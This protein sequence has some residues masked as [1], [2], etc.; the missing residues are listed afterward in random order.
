MTTKRIGYSRISTADQT[1]DSQKDA[2]LKAGVDYIYSDIYTGTKAS[3]PELDR[4]KDQ[5]R[6]G[7]TIVIT[8]LDRLGRSTKDL[9]K[10]SNDFSQNKHCS[11]DVFRRQVCL[12]DC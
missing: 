2:L 5:L 6:A 8:R 7:D 9:Q 11:A 3:R 12:C 4:L 1:V 10:I